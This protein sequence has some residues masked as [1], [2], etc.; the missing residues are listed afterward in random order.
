MIDYKNSKIQEDEFNLCDAILFVCC[1]VLFIMI[2][3]IY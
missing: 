1:V 2:Y 3:I